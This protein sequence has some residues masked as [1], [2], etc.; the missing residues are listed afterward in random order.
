M[1]T[2][3]N[4]LQPT[5]SLRLSVLVGLAVLL[6][7]NS[8]VRAGTFTTTFASDPGGTALGIAEV[9]DGVLKLTDL[10]D[11]P[12]AEPAKPLPQNG[13]YVLPEFNGGE[14]IQSF[15][16]TFKAAVG[17]GSSLGAQGFSFVLAGDLPS[18]PATTFR[19]GG[20]TS[21]GL[22]ISFDTIDNLAGF[23]AEGNDPGDAPGIIVKIGGAKVA[24]RS[25]RGIQT[26][27]ANST[28]TR[29]APVEVKLEADGTLDVTYDGIK[30]Y[31][32]VGI[33]YTP[34]A[35]QFGFGAGTAELTAAIRNNHWI[36]DVNITTTTVGAGAFVS[37][38]SPGAQQARADTA[39]TITVQNLASTTV[40]M[41]LDG[42]PVIPVVSSTGNTRTFTYDPPGLLAS[43][44]T[45]KVELT[46]D[47]NKKFSFD[48]TVANYPTIP[49]TAKAKGTVTTT[50]SGFKT[51]VYQ[52]SGAVLSS[53]AQAERQLAGLAG[54][55][56]ADLSGATGGTFTLGTINF[57]DDQAGVG[58]FPND[59][60]IPGYPGLTTEG[61]E[62]LDNV[63]VESIGY[64]EL[65]AGL[66]TLG[67]TSDDGFQVSV[68]GDPRD[69]TSPVVGKFEGVSTST[70][71]FVVEEAGIYPIR[72]LWY[73]GGGDAHAELYSLNT[74]G[75]RILLNDRSTAGHIKSYSERTG[76]L[77]PYVSSATPA[78]SATAADPK[79]NVQAVITEDTTV[80]TPASIQMRIKDTVVIP[81]LS[82]NGKQTTVTYTH[83]GHVPQGT[84]PVS[85]SYTDGSGNTVVS[86]W[87][88]T[89]SPGSCEN[90]AG[91][92]VTA[93][94]NFADATLNGD[95]GSPITYIDPALSTHYSF[96]TS[97]QGAFADVPG[98]NGQ[99]VKFLSI[100]RN[101]NG[102]DFKRTGLRVR[103][104]IAPSGG[105]QNANVWTLIMDLYWGEGHSH[106]T[107]LRTHDLNLDNDGD[108]FWQEATRAYGK[109]CCSDYTGMDPAKGHAR[110]TWARVVFVA[111]MTANPKRFSKYIN[112]VKHR[113]NVTG[114]GANID[115]RFSLPGEIFMFNDGDDNEQSSVL[116]SAIQ[117]RAGALTDA[118]VA[119]LNGPAPEGIPVPAGAGQPSGVTGQWEFNGNLNASSG[120]P[121]AF[122]DPALSPHYSFGT[123][124][125]GAF[126]DIP[127]INGQPAQF[128]AIP[129]NE[130]G[131]DFKRTGLRV[132]P[133]I[134]AN[135]GGNNANVWTLVMDVYWGDGHS[136]GTVLR[137]HDLNLDN[138][139]DLFWQ[140]ATRAYGKGCCSDYTGM[141]LAKGHARHTWARVAFV[142]DMTANPKRFSKYINGV[143][144]RDNVTGDGANID[145]RFSLPA[146]IFMFNDGDDN[147]QST[148]LINSIQYLP[149]ALSDAEVAALGG[150]SAS[151]I[152]EPQT[153]SPKIKGHWN[154][155][156]NL[157]ATVGAPI[158]FI[159]P[160]LSAN[161]SFGTAGQGAFVDVP[162]INGQPT[163]VLL[164]PRNENGTDFKRT[165]LKVNPGIAA[166]G[167]GANANVWTMIMDV[168]WGEG[169][170][171]GTVLRTHDL[172]LDNDGDLFWQ[173]ATRAYG[174]GCCSDYTGLDPAK[175]HARHT[176][177]RAVFVADMTA[178]PK[179]FSKYING[180]KHRDNVTGDGAN[181]DGRFTLP[182]LIY[183]FNDG[184]DNE[185]SSVYINAIQFREGA[186]TDEE[187][188]ALNGPTPDGP[189]LTAEA[190]ERCLP[191]MGLSGGTELFAADVV[192][193]PYTAEAGATF[194]A[195]AKTVTAP[196]ST[197]TR[198]YRLRAGSALR[199]TNASLQ[200]G[201][202]VLS[203]Q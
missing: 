172:N 186:M 136:H 175:G 79:L 149:E 158:A 36:D 120:S 28:A 57:D 178:S 13:S 43:G 197:R 146:E 145:G 179:R 26:Y 7:S 144:H 97:G 16:A 159:D 110:Q 153:I 157:N 59:E 176:W 42:Q 69:V 143:K 12:P 171:H 52:A 46:Y 4:S 9:E 195:T 113:D 182:S 91:P 119:A 129:R 198:F 103:P 40:Q 187:V 44:S 62:F 169:H 58:N 140:E 201:N 20:G 152:P 192:T 47:T 118:E 185:Q 173:E 81:T 34:I 147:E 80:L 106:G 102:T 23:N 170:S 22:V 55:N 14:A 101:D 166:N 189:P 6:L 181:I 155:D 72:F 56:L 63:V 165:G 51:R 89:T 122:I 19:E 142:A 3:T 202:L 71:S 24:A 117:Y 114:D 25:F 77:P 18:D 74:A 5:A 48:F 96:G 87:S 38:K 168:Y 167:G 45:H 70:F 1:H 193:G 15:T 150:A 98:I 53:L 188:A 21:Q 156:G 180:V 76:A 203:Y 61:V 104:G 10:A 17:G 177:A 95:I 111:D 128:L 85:L 37:A 27:P 65:P 133:G 99:A 84:Y 196:R 78:P 124:G 127:G 29:F 49:A 138:D 161:Y 88:F 190:A 94:W 184:D 139:G 11:L 183:M 115:G 132:R 194:N 33:G 131:T 50:S 191:L 41:T 75:E 109:G 162:G 107:V 73:E 35:G 100:P 64:L 121:V 125:Q 92:E 2:T 105:G 174:K 163:Q 126:A 123:S 39:V 164:I 108:L 93:Y 112:G 134:P 32:N 68:G 90:V 148:V 199:I 8:A 86:S 30:V 66:V 137:T 82:K 60:P 160:A 130:N 54:P 151:G 135:G 116:V 200:G 141:D 67:V 31:D 83:A 154:F